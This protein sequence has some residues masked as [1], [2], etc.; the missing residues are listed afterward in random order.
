MEDCTDC[1]QCIDNC[2][3]GC[4]DEKIPLIDI[5]RCFTFLNEVKKENHIHGKD[6]LKDTLLGCNI[7]Q[8]SCPLN[9]DFISIKEGP[10]CFDIK[11]TSDILKKSTIKRLDEDTRLKIAD[12]GIDNYYDT[13]RN[14]L[15]LILNMKKAGK[16]SQLSR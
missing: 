6:V 13:I 11:E 9:K 5:S 8:E 2:P 16:S 14:N 10:L 1:R 4:I 12:L 15:R 3:N 7:C